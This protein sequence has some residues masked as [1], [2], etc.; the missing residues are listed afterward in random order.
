MRVGE[1]K[2]FEWPMGDIGY[3][4]VWPSYADA[5][6]VYN[7]DPC[8]ITHITHPDP[9]VR[10]TGVAGCRFDRHPNAILLIAHRFLLPRASEHVYPRSKALTLEIT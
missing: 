2:N 1:R 9:N 7:G 8:T 10:Q 6:P 4:T 5:L 3:A